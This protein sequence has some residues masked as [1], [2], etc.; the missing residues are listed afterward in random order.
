M[1]IPKELKK[2]DVIFFNDER[3]I[4]NIKFYARN[5]G[6]FSVRHGGDHGPGR[7]ETVEFA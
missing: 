3:Y 7:V 1:A 2:I 5:G 4:Y 6:E